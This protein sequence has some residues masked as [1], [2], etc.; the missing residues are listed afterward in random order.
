MTWNLAFKFP[1]GMS[2]HSNSLLG[3]GCGFTWSAAHFWVCN[4]ISS[5]RQYAEAHVIAQLIPKP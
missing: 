3:F 2:L 4:V 5:P 1:S